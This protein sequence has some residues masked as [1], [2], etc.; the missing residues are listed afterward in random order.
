MTNILLFNNIC[1]L[2]I[3]YFTWNYSFGEILY[4]SVSST[5][6]GKSRLSRLFRIN[7]VRIYWMISFKA[8]GKLCV[9]EIYEK[10]KNLFK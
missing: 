5:S 6:D 9:A 7:I 10:K 8:Y 2:N 1:K 3:Y 4:Q